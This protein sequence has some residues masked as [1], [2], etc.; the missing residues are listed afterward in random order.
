MRLHYLFTLLLTLGSLLLVQSCKINNAVTHTAPAEIN[1]KTYEMNES[2]V[3]WDNVFNGIAGL[4]V[5]GRSPN[6]SFNVRGYNTIMGSSQPLFVLEGLPLGHDF[7]SLEGA[8]LAEQVHQIKVLKG[9]EASE[10]G[11]RGSNGVI[12]VTMKK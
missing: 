3:T 7:A 11:V 4:R 10:Y 5:T 2:Q 8:I 12:E 6:L 9:P 1:D